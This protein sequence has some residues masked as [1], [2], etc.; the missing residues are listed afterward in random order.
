MLI[1]T[2]G[3]EANAP[4]ISPFSK[5][6][7]LMGCCLRPEELTLYQTVNEVKNQYRTGNFSKAVRCYRC[8]TVL[9]HSLIKKSFL[10][11]TV[12]I[13]CPQCGLTHEG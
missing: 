13:E 12:R 6:M 10:G 11:M 1:Q 2:R 9:N 8:N 4:R 5:D 3:V 7:D